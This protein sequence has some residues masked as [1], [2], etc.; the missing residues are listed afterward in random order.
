MAT[1]G[2][3]G[4]QGSTLQQHVQTMSS[5]VVQASSGQC[6]NARRKAIEMTL[7]KFR[8]EA[9][10]W[11]VALALLDATVAAPTQANSPVL[12]LFAGNTLHEKVRFDAADMTPAQLLELRGRVL[13]SLAAACAHPQLRVARRS[14]GATVA[15][16]AVQLSQQWPNVVASL[17][18]L[19]GGVAGGGGAVTLQAAGV[20]GLVTVLRDLPFECGV[21]RTGPHPDAKEALSRQLA[22]DTP[23]VCRVLEGAFAAVGGDAT[24]ATACLECLGEWVQYADMPPDVLAGSALPAA[25]FSAL[26][27]PSLFDACVSVI[28]DMLHRYRDPERDAAMIGHIVPQV[29]AL[30]PAF[31]AAMGR[32]D[33]ESAVGLARIFN[34][35]GVA[36]V[37]FILSTANGG[38][39]TAVCDVCLAPL[40]AED[41]DISRQV[42]EFWNALGAEF[43]RLSAKDMNGRRPLLAPI[44]LRL[45]RDMLG[46]AA[47]CRGWDSE[48]ADVQ[49]DFIL[50]ARLSHRDILVD[51]CRVADVQHVLGVVVGFLEQQVALAGAVGSLAPD[52]PRDQ[53][54]AAVASKGDAGLAAAAEATPLRLNPGSWQAVEVAV[55]ALQHILRQLP[56]TEDSVMPR[57]LRQRVLASLPSHPRMLQA[58]FGLVGAGSRW[59]ARRAVGG[60]PAP[61]HE[62]WGLVLHALSLIQAAGA[63]AADTVPF[64]KAA[65]AAC[66]DLAIDAGRQLPPDALTTLSP[67]A[68]AV[69]LGR[70]EYLIRA[71]ARLAIARE[72]E[73]AQ[74]EAFM[75]LLQPP[76]AALQDIVRAPLASAV[77]LGTPQSALSAL[78]GGGEGDL[79]SVSALSPALCERVVDCLRRMC[80]VVIEVSRSD[81][82]QPYRMTLTVQGHSGP[83]HPALDALQEVWPLLQAVG[84]GCAPSTEV[85]EDLARLIKHCVIGANKGGGCVLEAVLQFAAQRVDDGVALTVQ[86]HLAKLGGEDRLRALVPV[87]P[88]ADAVT[89]LRLTSPLVHPEAP[90]LVPMGF[91]HLCAS[92]MSRFGGVADTAPFFMALVERLTTRCAALLPLLPLADG[93]AAELANGVAADPVNA[94]REV[95]VGAMCLDPATRAAVAGGLLRINCH[96]DVAG[97]LLRVHSQATLSCPRAYLSAPSISTA[98]NFAMVCLL[99]ADQTLGREV[100]AFWCNF[101]SIH[102]D[103]ALGS[104]TSAQAGALWA[105][106]QPLAP[107]LV[108]ILLS[109]VMGGVPEQ[110]LRRYES[111]LS[112]VWLSLADVV[113]AAQLEAAVWASL[114]AGTMPPGT[115]TWEQ[116]QRQ[117]VQDLLTEKAPG[118]LFDIFCHVHDRA[119]RARQEAADDTTARAVVAEA[120]AGAAAGSA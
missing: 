113:P 82:F 49:K 101:L 103:K 22:R 92:L 18:E 63:S 99:T 76:V 80:A 108:D 15:A 48:P 4:P 78:G 38:D 100:C 47:C 39:V 45:A 112:D 120:L 51:C 104:D 105:V 74:R 40:A 17:V 30:G 43:S 96:P 65:C 16:L 59:L 57:L 119:T 12:L 50:E 24:L 115:I 71:A 20:P 11:S 1:G 26:A 118:E 6:G 33:V 32:E 75:A 36:F 34:A 13:R 54:L 68:A 60:D 62:C 95:H 27:S 77:A 70:H 56:L 73:A 93:V 35:L 55:F 102:L 42:L 109:A 7:R 3:A 72:G 23:L 66:M 110:V 94:L 53:A 5:L 19:F 61:L 58:V 67:L 28:I 88:D 83:K 87:P 37:P 44:A 64:F 111:P 79:R 31:T 29:L 25:V 117:F 97:D 90:L 69:P 14:L 8:Q 85:Q 89:L 41:D 2:Q 84:Q 106:L 10:A 46:V 91:V 116:G 86:G 107:Q 9:S 52:A 21:R 114:R 98:L 81:E